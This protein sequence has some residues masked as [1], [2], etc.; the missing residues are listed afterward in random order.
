MTTITTS[1]LPNTNKELLTQL[2]VI[3]GLQFAHLAWSHLSHHHVLVAVMGASSVQHKGY[4]GRH[5]G[6][7]SS[8]NNKGKSMENECCNAKNA[9]SAVRSAK[10]MSGTTRACAAAQIMEATG[11][12]EITKQKAPC[13]AM[14]N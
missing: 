3:P 12:E 13:S 14:S 1:L 8:M 4:V 2:G 7:R 6:L 5:Q 9:R 11:K 10:E